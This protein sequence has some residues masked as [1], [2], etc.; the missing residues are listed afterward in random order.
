EQRDLRGDHD[1]Q[2]QQSDE[3][4]EQVQHVSCMPN[5][6]ARCKGGFIRRVQPLSWHSRRGFDSG[7]IRLEGYAMKPLE[8]NA[9]LTRRQWIGGAAALGAGAAAGGFPALAQAGS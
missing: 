8:W 2:G 3:D 1:H 9:M 4:R 7:R 5:T 6:A